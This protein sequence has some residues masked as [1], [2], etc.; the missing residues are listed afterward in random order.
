MNRNLAV[1]AATFIAA[2]IPAHGASLLFTF[3]S[4]SGLLGNSQIYGNA[5]DDITA[6][7]FYGTSN[8]HQN[9]ATDLYSKHSGGDESGLGLSRDSSEHEIQTN[10]FIQ[11]DFSDVE[12]LGIT[13]VQFEMGSTQT[14]EGWAVYGSNTLGLIGTRISSNQTGWGTADSTLL[15]LPSL[16]NYTYFAFTA[17]DLDGHH[18]DANVLLSEIQVTT[19]NNASATPEPSTYLLAGVALILISKIGRRH[20]SGSR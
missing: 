13:Q 10:D 9:T 8:T 17:V 7:G 16:S 4:P 12:A 20:R 19:G 18:P 14:G 11:I 1:T 3:T 6:Y 2:I 15:T 5:P